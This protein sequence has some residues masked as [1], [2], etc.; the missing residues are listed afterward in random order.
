[1]MKSPVASMIRAAPTGTATDPAGPAAMIRSPCVTTTALAIGAPPRPSI[2]VP[3]VI[4]TIGSLLRSTGGIGRRRASSVA[5]G[6][7]A[8][9]ARPGAGITATDSIRPSATLPALRTSRTG[10]R[11]EILAMTTSE[12]NVKIHMN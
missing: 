3:P 8:G 2:S 7:G 10:R 5:S 11:R 12:E 9:A 4:T 1:M 6:I